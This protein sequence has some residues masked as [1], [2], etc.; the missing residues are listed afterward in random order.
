MRE[1]F[2]ASAGEREL[3][4]GSRIINVIALAITVLLALGGCGGGGGGGGG[5]GNS[6]GGSVVAP[7]VITAILGSFPAGHVLSGV[8]PAGFN[9]A[10]QVVVQDGST[11]AIIT[12]ASVTVN[13]VNLPYN[14]ADQA[15][16]A[17]LNVSPGDALTLTVTFSGTTYSASATQF[18]TYPQITNPTLGTIWGANA[19]NT[20]G[21]A[22][23]VPTSNSGYALEVLDAADPNG[24]A[25]WPPGGTAQAVSASSTSFTIAPNSISPGNRDILLAIASAVPV[26]GAG[27]SS[28]F[29]FAAFSYLPITVSSAFGATL[30]SI[31]VT[32][33]NQ[34]ITP[35]GTLQLAAKGTYSDSSISDL[36]SQVTWASSDT[37]KVTVSGTGLASGVAAGSATVTAT[38]GGISGSATESVGSPVVSSGNWATFQGD[39]A[40][41]GYVNLTL[42]PSRFTP[43]WTWS[44]PAG[45]PE[46]VGGI[47]AVATAG[48]K[49]FVTKDIY[50]GQG[51][52]YALNETDGSMAWIYA[53]GQMASEGPPAYGNGSVFVP[54][55][56]P[57]EN[58]V[59]WAV[60]AANGL[61][62]FSMPTSCQWSGYF[63]PTPSGSSVL[64]TSQA[65]NTYSFSILTGGLQWTTQAGASDQTTPAADAQ[66]VYQ[67]GVGA[68]RVMDRVT[69]ALAASITDPF[70]SGF[71]GYSIFSAPMIGASNDVIV[72][73]NAGFSGRA[74]S[75]SEQ[76]ASRVLVSYN[77]SAHSYS[78]RSANAYLTHP[79]IASGVIYAGRNGPMAL[80]ALSETDGHVIW[81]WTPPAGNSSLHRNVVVTNNLVF[82]ST[83][84]NVYAIDLNTHL[85]VWQYP[86][87]G[88]L[89]ISG[90]GMLYIVTG[91][92]ISDGNL[93]AI[94]LQ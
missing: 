23:A 69:G 32:P 24:N 33:N 52:L 47:N 13:G 14:S 26:P 11:G 1:R 56:D 35:G 73:S 12:S 84:A 92:T 90:S 93:V 17:S 74:A 78:W 31:A 51:A 36:T 75:S 19:S 46:P 37:S 27:S 77:I 42:D 61:F 18:T 3:L 28:F 50:F 21:W 43:L 59:M 89:A 91:A 22:P 34:I 2:P 10:A 71:T 49:V 64:Q 54:S 25:I 30:T 20:V 72:F 5:P 7:P 81:S 87:A 48:G 44:R 29:G 60:N 55:T 41:T 88:M 66:Y 82:V 83:D 58:C 6:G 39:A 68:L 57:S 79:A 70:A 85:T 53:L 62:Q 86:K 16:E 76:G 38:L 8:V 67:Y 40:H 15:Y 9:S 63:A 94:K 80:D 65:G 4:T 45:D